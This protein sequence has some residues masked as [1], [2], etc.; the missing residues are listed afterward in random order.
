M[1]LYSQLAD[2]VVVLHALYV[3]VVVLGLLAVIV[4]A[5]LRW[6]W[7]RN[8]WFRVIHL[9]MI[10]IVALEAVAGIPC[11]LTVWE[12]EL[13]L[14]AGQPVQ[15]DSFVGRCFQNLIFYE[16]PPW[17]FTTLHCLFFVAVLATLIWVPPRW[18]RSAAAGGPR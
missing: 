7:V 10:G 6:Q 8:F 3:A 5:V 11:P 2:A 14:A 18:P 4:G 16:G 12:A 15:A 9:C 1:Y 17:V 13:R